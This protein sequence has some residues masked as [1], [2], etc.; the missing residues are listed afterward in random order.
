MSQLVGSL[1]A[2]GLLGL[3]AWALIIVWRAPFRA[4]GLLVAGMAFH[5]FVLMAL[6]G[7]RTPA[8]LVRV[9]QLWKEGILVLLAILVL[10]AGWRA[11]RSGRRPRLAL[12]DWVAIA[13]TA[14]TII[15]FVLPDSLLH[16]SA[17][18]HQRLIG[19]RIVSLI[20]ALYL[21]GRVFPPAR[22]QDLKWVVLVIVG[23]GAVVGLFGLIELWLIPTD[24][25]LS[26]GVNEFSAWLGFV[27]N[28]P[29]G[30]PA[31]FFQTTAEGFLLRRMVSTYVSPLGIAYAGLLVIPIAGALLLQRDNRSWAR[32]GSRWILWLAAI[33]LVAGILFSL[34]RLALALMVLELFFLA[35]LFRRRWLLYATPLAGLMVLFMLFQYVQVGPLLDRNL[36]PIANRPAHLHIATAA[37]P[38]L[39]EHT[40]FLGY[41]IRYV[42]AHPLGTGLGSSVHRFGSSE[43]TGESAVFGVFGDLG[44]AGGLLYLVLYLGSAVAGA[45]AYLRLRKD[46][47]VA[48]LPLVAFVGGLGLFAIT[49]TSDVWGDFATTFLFWWAA[50]ASVTLAATGAAIAKPVPASG[51]ADRGPSSSRSTAAR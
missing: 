48:A 42:L 17:N 24:V 27:Y 35:V 15:Y 44:V 18:L 1:L 28:G 2:L 39:K 21:F 20:P 4:L 13:L 5:N 32:R 29:K 36:Q 12:L 34:T 31:N 6:L 51:V 33:L 25:W 23:A 50:G 22:R 37:D 14:A 10:M 41:D 49:L 16:G 7:L 47:L 8:L 46:P 9:V 45:L 43:G 30:L 11:W 3:I 40:G 26:W 19:L 38:S